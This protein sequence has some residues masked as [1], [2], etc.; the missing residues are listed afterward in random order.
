MGLVRG[1]FWVYLRVGA[2]CLG[3]VYRHREGHMGVRAHKDL[4]N[5]IGLSSAATIKLLCVLLDSS[6]GLGLGLWQ[7]CL[8]LPPFTLS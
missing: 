6:L 8:A 5:G 3:L 4:H 2:L 7:P 1:G